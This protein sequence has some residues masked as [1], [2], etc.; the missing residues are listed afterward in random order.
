[1]AF[2]YHKAMDIQQA[3]INTLRGVIVAQMIVIG[4]LWYGWQ[5]APR[6]LTVHLPPDIRAG[7]SLGPARCRQ[8]VYA[9]GQYIFQQLNRWETDGQKEAGS[10]C[11]R[12]RPT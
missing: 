11:M 4:A 7:T 8:S 3:H 2:V 6:D 5:S 12:C 9:F 1:M 10:G